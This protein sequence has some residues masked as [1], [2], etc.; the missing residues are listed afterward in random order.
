M[1]IEC[2]LCPTDLS[3]DSDEALR[4]AVALTRAYDAELILLHCDQSE[5]AQ[6]KPYANEKAALTIREA[7]VKYSGSDDLNGLDWRTLVVSCDDIGAA[8]A[9]E[10]GKLGVD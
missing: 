3:A 7:L 5:E 6:S 8:I 1:K 4:Y 2:I 9:R 10:A